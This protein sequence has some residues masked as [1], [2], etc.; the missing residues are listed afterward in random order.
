LCALSNRRRTVAD[1]NLRDEQDRNKELQLRLLAAGSA[2]EYVRREVGVF[3]HE[4]EED[5]EEVGAGVLGREDDAMGDFLSSGFGPDD[6]IAFEIDIRYAR[7][8]AGEPSGRFSAFAEIPTPTSLLWVCAQLCEIGDEVVLRHRFAASHV[9]EI[10]AP[11]PFSMDE[12]VAM[13]SPHADQ[14]TNDGTDVISLMAADLVSPSEAIAHLVQGDE[15][16]AVMD[17]EMG[18]LIGG[19]VRGV[20]RRA[21]I[22]SL[23]ALFGGVGLGWLARRVLRG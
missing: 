6:L 4:E 22:I 14:L 2:E 19:V 15:D 18:E 10:S 11:W 3:F 12:A 21:A 1:M 16:G 5:V 13:T 23:V 9:V 17:E 8:G 7:P 20:V